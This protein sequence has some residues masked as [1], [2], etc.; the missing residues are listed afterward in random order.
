LGIYQKGFLDD[1]FF[2][3]PNG[4]LTFVVTQNKF[5]SIFSKFNGK[6][7]FFYRQLKKNL[8]ALKIHNCEL[9]SLQ[10]VD[11]EVAARRNVKIVGLKC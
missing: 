3:V 11:D 10:A 4:D 8:E 9:V 1:D 7:I 5:A 2:E 6:Y